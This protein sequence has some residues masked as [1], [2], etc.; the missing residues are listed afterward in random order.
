MTEPT[1][2]QPTPVVTG[3]EEVLQP[4][5]PKEEKALDR[6]ISTPE[7]VFKIVGASDRG[8]AEKKLNESY[9]AFT[10]ILENKE[11]ELFKEPLS[12][13]LN[14]Q[15]KA[16]INLRE[17]LEGPI[18]I[19]RDIDYTDP[20]SVDKAVQATFDALKLKDTL[21]GAGMTEQEQAIKESI[22]RRILF[23][24]YAA[25]A[26]IREFQAKSAFDEL[27]QEI[28]ALEAL[29]TTSDTIPEEIRKLLSEGKLD[30]ENREK[31]KKNLPPV[32]KYPDLYV[33]TDE[34]GKRMVIIQEINDKNVEEAI[35]QLKDSPVLNWTGIEK[36]SD[37]LLVDI[38]CINAG[39]RA[40][41]GDTREP[42]PYSKCMPNDPGNW[43]EFY[44][45]VCEEESANI[46]R[47]AW[48]KGHP[49]AEYFVAKAVTDA[50]VHAFWKSVSEGKAVERTKIAEMLSQKQVEKLNEQYKNEI[51]ELKRQI[52][53]PTGSAFEQAQRQARLED[54]KQ[55]YLK[56]ISS[57]PEEQYKKYLGK[58]NDIPG[59]TKE[60][61]EEARFNTQNE[62]HQQGINAL[63]ATKDAAKIEDAM[64]KYVDFIAKN[65]TEGNLK[66]NKLEEA[67]R[68]ISDQSLQN[69]IKE[70][71]QN[72]IQPTSLALH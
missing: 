66:G 60:E 4:A 19:Q 20:K 9:A 1:K 28:V 46:T 54:A 29:R 33:A 42:G 48:Q 36:S 68:N 69:K 10:T 62:V 59:I 16:Y 5:Q 70:Q 56:F 64:K 44:R 11:K 3:T 35:K 34:S 17:K 71:V 32:D 30:A 50:N 31:I 61:V 45:K 38:A 43:L 40:N 39:K 21:T 52:D 6:S 14:G 25:I 63:D 72:K 47:P 22:K 37:K 7:R 24:Q 15:Q 57:L 41:F 13:Q 8:D 12:A 67:I 53:S 49:T 55:E 51:N 58:L 18:P 27:Q 23:K 65:I 26:Q 2:G